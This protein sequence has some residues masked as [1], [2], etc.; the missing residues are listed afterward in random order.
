MKEREWEWEWPDDWIVL[1]KYVILFIYLECLSSA[2]PSCV[3]FLLL[4]LCI[5][6]QSF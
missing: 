5:F 6:D 3:S 1:T 2:L 4:V